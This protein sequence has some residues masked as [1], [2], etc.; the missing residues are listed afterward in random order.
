MPR[1]GIRRSRTHQM[2]KSNRQ[3]IR[4]LADDLAVQVAPPDLTFADPNSQ[5]G[6][7]KRTS[8]LLCAPVI[9]RTRLGGSI[10]RPSS[11]VSARRYKEEIENH[12]DE[13]STSSFI[14]EEWV[15]MQPLMGIPDW[16]PGE[17]PRALS[18][19]SVTEDVFD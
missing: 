8:K 16:N 11:R 13:H 1:G 4:K 18:V 6:R 14:Q 9:E 7:W 12:L 15:N 17:A 10:V 19:F 2:G 5:I 3:R